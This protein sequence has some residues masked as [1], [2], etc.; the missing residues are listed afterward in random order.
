MWLGEAV[1]PRVNTYFCEASKTW[2]VRNEVWWQ[3]PVA[4][5][6]FVTVTV[7]ED[8]ACRHD[9]VPIAAPKCRDELKRS[10]AQAR[11]IREHRQGRP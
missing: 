7:T 1:G 11:P 2:H 6:I 8:L 10:H 4:R 9:C 3:V 5:A